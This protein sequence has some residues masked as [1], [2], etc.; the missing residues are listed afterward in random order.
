M[1]LTEG[2]RLSGRSQ[3]L[4]RVEPHR[5]EQSVADLSLGGL[6]R[7]ERFVDERAEEGHDG[8]VRDVSV[9]ADPFGGVE[10]EGT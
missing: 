3:V 8:S 4:G 1:A 10:A 5:L 7:D 2:L 6:R 9:R